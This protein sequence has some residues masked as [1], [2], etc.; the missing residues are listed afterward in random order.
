M[1]LADLSMPQYLYLGAVGCYLLFFALFLRLFWWKRY[2]DTHFWRRRPALSIEGVT[3]KAREEGMALPRFSI[4][5]PAR[6]EAD[7]IERTVEHMSALQYPPEYYEVL[8]VTDEKEARAADESRERAVR[9]AAAAIRQRVPALD[10]LDEEREA[11]GLVVALLGALSLDG[12]E[13]VRRRLGRSVGVHLLQQVAPPLLRPLVWEAADWL[14]HRKGHR[15]APHL[16]RLLRMRI[17]RATD[18]ELQGAYAALLSLAIPTAVAYHTMRGGDGQALGQR[19]ASVAAQAHHALT[20][21]ILQSMVGALAA[22]LLERL[23]EAGRDEALP[24]R[25]AATYREIYPTT[26]DI[27]ERKLREFAGR[28]DLPAL[29]HVVVPYD[30]DGH[31]G[32][33]RLG[34]EVPSTKGRALNWALD[35]IDGRS[36]WCGFYDAESRPDPRV[37][38]YVAH[39]VLEAREW[40]V[41]PPRIFQGPVFQVRNWYEM[42]PFCKIASLY[43]AIAHDWY[44]PALFQ[45][46]PF[47]GGT[48]LFVE[49]K[50]LRQIGGYDHTSLTED[51]ELG[52]RAYLMQD[53]WPEY[54][55][56]PSSEQTPPTFVGFYRQRL[57]WATGHLQVMAK[58]RSNPGY[59]PAR[60]GVLLRTL[61]RKGQGEWLFYQTATLVPPLVIILYL[62]DLIDPSV[63]GPSWHM[64]MNLL[65][66][67]YLG[68][69]VYAFFR[70]LEHLDETSRPRR[71]MGQMGALAQLL[72][73]PLAAFLFPVPYSSALV[74]AG[75]GRGPQQWVKTPRTRE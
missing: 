12:L 22:D 7:V 23:E 45:R 58:V 66:T 6:N 50:L 8:V 26:Q 41:E 25:L 54:L 36:V 16:L 70:Y 62:L 63:L 2:A 4:L 49:A 10:V 56:Y 27:M 74:L 43:Q 18:E 75:L 11:A 67:V 55:P 37:M 73:L 53:A 1:N 9:V 42:G 14:L 40:D 30:F 5:I 59:D 17:P 33:K 21:E 46:L 65:S 39:K 3:T 60:K 72:V 19:L 69:T 34:V 38:L 44:L 28:R 31:L 48:N 52:T 47:V 61:W 71:W 24:E 35:F 15:V 68:F 29:K 51:L 13:E 32:G 57:R 20:R 64:A